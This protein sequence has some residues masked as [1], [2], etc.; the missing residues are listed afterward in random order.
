MASRPEKGSEVEVLVDS[1]AFGG[2][3]VARLD[4]F[5]L[6]VDRALPG[7]RVRARV[8]K[9]KRSYGEARAVETIESGPDRVAAPCPHFGA[10]GGCRW[11]D[12]DYDAQLTWKAQQVG[13]AMARIGHQEGVVQDP[14]LPPTRPHGYRD[15]LEISF[16]PTGEGPAPGVPPGGRWGE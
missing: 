10:C 14:I 3:G 16:R 15:K 8:T 7:D 6:F 13:D 9:V 4:D 1:L 12:L 5:V 2:R 11:Q